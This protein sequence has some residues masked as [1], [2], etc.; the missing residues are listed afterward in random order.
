MVVVVVVVIV[1]VCAMQDCLELL[2]GREI[3]RLH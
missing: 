2:S 1:Q 3:V